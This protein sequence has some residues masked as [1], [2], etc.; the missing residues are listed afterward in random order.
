MAKAT[1]PISEHYAYHDDPIHVQP[2]QRKKGPSAIF[3]F[4]LIAVAAAYFI[5]T[6]LA[7]NISINSGSAVEFGQGSLQTVACSGATALTITPASTFTNSGGGGDFNFSSL[8]VSNI[9]SNCYGKKFTIRAYG[10]T[11]T[12]LAIFN[13]TSTSAVI[14]D[15]AGTFLLGTGTSGMSISSGSG[16]FTLTFTSPVALSSTV[17]KIS[18]ESSATT[19]AEGDNCVVGNTGPGGGTIFYVDLA[20]FNCGTSYTNTGSPTGGLCS[21]LEAA[22][23]GWANSGSPADDPIKLWAVTAYQSTD[24]AGIPNDPSANNSSTGIGL[25]YKNSIAIVGQ[26]GLYNASSNNYAAGAARAYAGGSKS[27]WYLPTTAEFNQMCKW[28][29]GVAFTSI[30]TVCTGGTIN[31]GVGAAGFVENFY[32]SSSELGTNLAWVQN[33]RSGDLVNWYKYLTS[34]FRPVRAF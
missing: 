8:S 1:D 21:Y 20:G 9:P 4:L 19:C 10:N 18:I 25:G 2:S 22:P 13:S 32:W 26:N 28:A 33:F 31:T 7:S 15:K 30:A 3:A 12:P 29:K 16:A 24:V 14:V 11:D 17:E 23:S 5:Q 27:D 6:T 34:Y